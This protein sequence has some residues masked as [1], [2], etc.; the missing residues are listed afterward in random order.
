MPDFSHKAHDRR[1]EGI[2]RGQMA[3]NLEIASLERSVLWTPHVQNQVLQ[4][5]RFINHA[6]ILLRIL[7]L[8]QPDEAGT[9]CILANSFV[10]LG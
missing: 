3:V 5:R 1:T 2:V 10:T 8:T 9:A 7:H 4:G 6:D